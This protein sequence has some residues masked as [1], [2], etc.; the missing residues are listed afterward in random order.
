M[1]KVLKGEVA[2]GGIEFRFV[3][4]DGRSLDVLLQ[5]SPLAVGGTVVGSLASIHDITDRKRMESA[6]RE[7]EGRFRSL[8]QN[9]PIGICILQDGRIVFANPE[10]ERLLG[11]LAKSVP[12]VR[13]LNFHPEDASVF[14]A[15]C[16]MGIPA[17]PLAKET[18]LRLL[19]CGEEDAAGETRWVRCKAGSVRYKERDAILLSMMD[20]TRA[21]D[22]EHLVVVQEKLA[23]LGQFSAGIAHEIRNPLS[24]INIYLSTLEQLFE[25]SAGMDTED[26]IRIHEILEKTRAA[27]TRI[28][29]V[30]QSV[31]EFSEPTPSRLVPVNVNRLAENAVQ[32]SGTVLRKHEIV[33]SEE[34]SPE[35]PRCH[36]DPR[37]IEQ[38]VLN[39]ITNAVQAMEI[40]AGLRR[41]EIASS[42]ENGRIVLRVSDSGPGVPLRIRRKIFDPFFTTRKEG[43]GIGL[44][45][46]HRVV[47]EHGGSLTVGTSKWGGAEFRIE[48]PLERQGAPA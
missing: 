14:E 1:R 27:S 34:L 12:S 6:L 21:K 18:D 41:L 31:M 15:L 38:V 30:I 39:L 17:D 4:R 35:L 40:R 28:A 36:A 42:A 11:P 7:S 3:T 46:S 2:P 20:V 13:Y 44:S 47:A 10:Q 43:Y 48:L 26:G 33:L 22:L 24:G 19:P 45:F 25:H 29:T 8:V 16:R 37:L 23:S 5:A 9:L 32:I